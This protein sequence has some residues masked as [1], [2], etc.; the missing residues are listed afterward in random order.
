M[1]IAITGAT[2][3]LGQLVVQKLKEKV[4][5]NEIVAVVRSAQK[6]ADLGVQARE[7][8]YD[9]TAALESALQGVDTLLLISA[10]DLTGK[11]V[12][13][14]SNII[15]AA[16]KSG[17]KW[18]VYTSILRADTSTIGLAKEHI[19]TENYLKNAGIPYTILRNGWYTENYAGSIGA[20]LG[21][22]SLLGSAGDGKIS[23]ATRAD[24]ADAAVAVLTTTGHEGKTYELAGDDA[25][26]LTELAA[27]ISRQSGKSVSYVNLSEAEYAAT[28]ASFGV[29]EAFAQVFAAWDAAT[30]I[31]DLYEDGRAL[32]KLTG[33]PTTPLTVAVAELVKG[34]GGH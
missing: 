14:H 24:F 9:N 17:V 22:G 11:R 18:I 29:P 19:Q 6:A 12:Q 4:S 32:S 5:A 1:S 31:G 7:A 34:G 27:E 30:E 26:T 16:K 21:S 23:S 10:N 3:Q 25:Y 28:L 20:A 8:D 15:D 33:K 2:G 13:Q